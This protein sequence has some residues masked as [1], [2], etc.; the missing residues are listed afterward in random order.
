[1]V[2]RCDVPM[3]WVSPNGLTNAVPTTVGVYE[4]EYGT[5]DRTGTWVAK[6]PVFM[7][8]GNAVESTTLPQGVGLGETP[9][10]PWELEVVSPL[11]DF[12]MSELD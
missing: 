11:A 8:D 5:Q 4:V 10:G 3:P 1:M 7:N 12:D 9:D 6:L 2:Y